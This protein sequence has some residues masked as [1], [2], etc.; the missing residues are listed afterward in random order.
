VNL[1]LHAR[2]GV[3]GIALLRPRVSRARYGVVCLL[4][5]PAVLA[6]SAWAIQH[7]PLDLLTVEMFFDAGSWSFPWRYSIWLEVFGHQAARAVPLMIGALAVAAGSAS[8]ALPGLRPWRRLLFALGVAIFLGPLLIA[9]LKTTTSQHCPAEISRFGGIV[10]YAVERDGP[11]FAHGSGK[12]GRCLPSGHAGGGYALLSLFF[13][14]WAAGR[15]V[16]RWTGLTVGITAGLLF[17]LVRIMQ[18]AQF[19]SATL[20][21]ATVDWTVAALVFMPL[22]CDPWTR[23]A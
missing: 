3:S 13:A 8:G 1:D 18:G 5:V 15:P 12:A 22:L 4:L 17:S 19:A 21:S 14:G 6:A 7:G 10:D 20:W 2:G 11:F 9:A 16:W 23:A